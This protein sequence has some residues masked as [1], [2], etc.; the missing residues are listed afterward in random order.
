MK[1]YLQIP[2][3]ILLG[4]I[5]AFSQSGN[6]A[7]S[8]GLSGGYA[9][10]GFG[11]MATYNY[12]LNRNRYAQLSVFAAIAEDKG[13]FD[14]PYN[15]FTVQPGYFIKVWEQKNFKKYGVNLGGGGIF[16]YEV[17]NNGNSL[18]SNGAILDAKSQFI[19]GVFIGVEGEITLSNDFS[20]LIKA[21]EYYHAN[22]DVGQFYPYAGLGLRYFLF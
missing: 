7:S 4:T 8:V 3:I 10:D 5:S 17:I 18:L 15:I 13:S 22:S 9:E 21:N 16:G 20:L 12:H 1:N 14:I 6:Y 11:I 19:Y 2:L